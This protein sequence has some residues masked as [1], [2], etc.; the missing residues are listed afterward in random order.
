MKSKYYR[1]TQIVLLGF[2]PKLTNE[3]IRISRFYEMKPILFCSKPLIP[4]LLLGRSRI[5]RFDL[6]DQQS[7]T[8]LCDYLNQLDI[9]GS[10]YR[11]LLFPLD[12]VYASFLKANEAKL[13]R[14][15]II[16]LPREGERPSD[17]LYGLEGEEEVAP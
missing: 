4:S 13:N 7:E 14:R 17:V 3:L 11:P 5:I 6:T 10:A 9:D 16:A 1:D 12:E 8:V 15:F 2:S